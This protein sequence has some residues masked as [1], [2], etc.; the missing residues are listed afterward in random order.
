MGPCRRRRRR[1]GEEKGGR[2]LLPHGYKVILLQGRSPIH[3]VQPTGNCAP[4]VPRAC[5]SVRHTHP[6][7]SPASPR[8]P[9]GRW[10]PSS[11][12][13]PLLLPSRAS[14]VGLRAS[15][16][17]PSGHWVASSKTWARGCRRPESV[18]K[19]GFRCRSVW[20][21]GAPRPRPVQPTSR[22]SIRPRAHNATLIRPGLHVR[23]RE[24]VGDR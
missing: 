17:P 21:G 5:P 19:C 18:L 3:F 22:A 7:P 11:G 16:R 9:S 2:R 13:T 8:P 20:G 6:R 1:M 4:S 12:S 23:V 10:A 15:P 24:G 14:P